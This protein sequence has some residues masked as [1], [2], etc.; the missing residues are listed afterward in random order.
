[1]PLEYLFPH[2]PPEETADTDFKLSVDPD[3]GGG[4]SDKD[5]NESSFGFFVLASPD[6]L[7]VSLDKRDGSHWEVFDC[8][9]SVSE[10]AQTVR[11]TCTDHSET[12]NCDRIYLGHGVPGT[13]LEMPSGVS[14]RPSR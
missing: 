4:D 14:V 6:E 7:Q 9:D 12:S 8:F 11:M 2:P 13:I 10:E 5:P 3:F 1:M